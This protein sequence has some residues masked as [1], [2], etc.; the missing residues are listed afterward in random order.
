MAAGSWAGG[1]N[2]ETLSDLGITEAGGLGAAAQ[3]MA[4]AGYS[5]EQIRNALASIESA[6]SGDYKA[7]GAWTGGNR[8]EERKA[9][10][11]YGRYQ[12]MGSNIGPW[13]EQ[14]LKQSGVTPEMFLA[15]P[16]LQDKLTDAVMGDYRQKYGDRGA[17][18]KWFTGSEKEPDRSDVHGKL[19]GKTY[20][21][22]AMEQLMRGSS[23]KGEAPGGAPIAPAVGGGAPAAAPDKGYDW[24]GAG[25]KMGEA[26]ASGEGMGGMQGTTVPDTP[27]AA[28]FQ[29]DPSG[30][31]PNN[32]E[33]RKQ[34]AQMMLARLNTGKLVV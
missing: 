31:D 19:T 22:M 5:P 15:D 6:G 16:A 24:A 28:M 12:I 32:L 14:Y 3:Q 34:L 27:K 30:L 13:A 26:M 23:A 17:F 33:R 10:R 25:K 8:G 1:F 21:D 11:A 2:P 9:D 20:A 29:A 7:L 18:S 4:A